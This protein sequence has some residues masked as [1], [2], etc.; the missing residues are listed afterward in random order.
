VTFT[1]SVAD[2]DPHRSIL[3]EVSWIRIHMEDVDLDHW[4]KKTEKI[5]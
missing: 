1:G 3:K 4:G 2:L 5:V